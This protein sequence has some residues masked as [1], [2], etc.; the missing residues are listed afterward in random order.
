MV[1]SCGNSQKIDTKYTN[2]KGRFKVAFLEIP[3]ETEELLDVDGGKIKRYLF[4]IY[5]KNNNNLAYQLSYLDLPKK[6]TDTLKNADIYL[7]LDDLRLSVLD[8]FQYRNLHI[9]NIELLGYLG[10]EY[11][12]QRDDTQDFF[13]V[14]AYLVGNSLYFISN[15]F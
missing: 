2:E 1:I 9:F 7:L 15:Y 11:H 3:K 6:I 5:P 8:N 12:M 10:R 4:S 13:K 14:R